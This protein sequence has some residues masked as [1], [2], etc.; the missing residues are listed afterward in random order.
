ME[1]ITTVFISYSWDN[2][3]HK[4]WVLN[5]ANKLTDNG[6]YVLLDRFDL[7]AG[8]PMTQFME[9]SVNNSNKVLLIMTPNYKD[10]ADN[11]TG[12]VGYE[13]S[14]ITQ[15]LYLKQDN[16]KFIPIIRQGNYNESA[17]KFLSTLISHDMRNDSTFEKDFSE[18]IK[19]IY[20]EPE[21]KRHPLGKKPTFVI[22][23]NLASNAILI[24]DKLNL[25]K[26]RMTT[27]AKWIID[28]ELQSLNDLSIPDLYAAITA[29]TPVDKEGKQL[30]PSILMTKYKISHHPTILYEIP[31]HQYFAYN[32]LIHEQLK[33]QQG[34]IHY[35]FSEYS[36]ND[37]WLLFLSR[38]FSC[39]FYLLIIIK[40]IHDK[41]TKV[42]DIKIRVSFESDK[43]SLLYGKHSPFNFGIIFE[44]YGIP[45]NKADVTIKLNLIS[46]DSVFKMF[47]TIYHMFVSENI[48]STRPYVSI[49][50]QHFDMVTEEFLK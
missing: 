50:R 44:H 43:R 23:T 22:N 46:K 13:Y 49:D 34:L 7:K 5:L 19:I 35:E 47:E 40:A 4:S 16:E 2:E 12:G 39:L 18:L 41:L 21:I 31:L 8:K 36:N 29:Y 30:L 28:I 25:E 15:E 26:S 27:Y 1:K 3:E 33:I 14:M 45:N 10:K 37:F 11:R 32:H 6:V 20:D 48:Q 42:I 17:P 38:P 24:D 9:K